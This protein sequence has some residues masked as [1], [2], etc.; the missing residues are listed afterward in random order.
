MH[1]RYILFL[2]LFI[3]AL[4]EGENEQQKRVSTLLPQA[5]TCLC[6]TYIDNHPL[7]SY[8]MNSCSIDTLKSAFVSIIAN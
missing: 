3:F 2:S 7:I 5:N 1:K 6:P 8:N 4:A